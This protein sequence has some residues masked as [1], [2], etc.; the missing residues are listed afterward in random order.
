MR[1]LNVCMLVNISSCIVPAPSVTV[2][3]PNNQSVGQPLTL[4]CKLTT[5]RG[6]TS[7]V[8]VVWSNNGTVLERVIGVNISSITSNTTTYIDTYTIQ[9]LTVADDGKVYSCKILIN[10]H[11]TIT[12]NSSI[13][14]DVVG[15]HF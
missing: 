15:K 11:P 12:M 2:T 1:N 4:K 14:L 5:V 6:I 9:L 13:I 3:A 8:D 10:A 7:R